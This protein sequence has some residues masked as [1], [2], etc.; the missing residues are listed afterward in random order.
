MGIIIALL[1]YFLFQP[2]V[3]ELPEP[4]TIQTIHT[5]GQMFAFNILQLNT[6]SR[7]GNIHNIFWSMPIIQLF[8]HCEYIKGKPVLQDYN[9][10]VF[11]RILAFYN[12]DSIK[13]S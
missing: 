12:N 4:I 10:E 2:T 9:P 8:S 7:E 3:K 1:I 11:R 5:D 13:L 6:L